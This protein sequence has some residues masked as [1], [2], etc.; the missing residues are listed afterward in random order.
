MASH[1]SGPETRLLLWEGE[2]QPAG[3]LG[4]GGR[5]ATGP[6]TRRRDT[7]RGTAGQR[8]SETEKQGERQPPKRERSGERE[9]KR[10]VR[11]WRKCLTP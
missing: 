6:G 1:C 11:S 4:A 3:A 5:G 7:E 8:Q 9:V 10:S 2:S